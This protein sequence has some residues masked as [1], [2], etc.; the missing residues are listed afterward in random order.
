MPK[1]PPQSVLLCETCGYEITGLDAP[2]NCPE[3]ARPVAT[4]L[5]AARRGSPFQR[6]RTPRALVATSYL[7]LRNP[8][9]LFRIVSIEPRTSRLL[10]RLNILIAAVLLSPGPWTTF[11]RV[12]N[13]QPALA[14]AVHLT[15]G[16]AA[17][18]LLTRIEMIG[19]RAFGNRRGWRITPTVA[20]T[21]CAHASVGWVLTGVL[22][23]ASL[24][25]PLP[26]KLIILGR[27][28]GPTII[29]LTSIL[30]PAISLLLGMF[31]FELLVYLGVRR[32][33]YANHASASPASDPAVPTAVLPQSNPQSPPTPA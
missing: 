22:F 29:D 2:M 15:L 18:W 8:N 17:L 9:A 30:V 19:I 5:P 3:C 25:V 21:I 24:V 23:L 33:R 12:L 4:S 14:W 7:A 11:M 1:A 32:C 31:V 13:H 10:L 6:R 20:L 16:A 27:A 26:H 28:A